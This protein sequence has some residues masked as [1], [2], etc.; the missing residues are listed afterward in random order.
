M[1]LLLVLLKE[2]AIEFPFGIWVKMI[3]NIDNE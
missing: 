3:M 2:V 1:M